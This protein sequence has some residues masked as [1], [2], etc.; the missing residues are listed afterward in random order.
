MLLILKQV[1]DCQRRFGSSD[2]V[3][4]P[5]LRAAAAQRV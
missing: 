5:S 4:P 3:A 1:A 2:A